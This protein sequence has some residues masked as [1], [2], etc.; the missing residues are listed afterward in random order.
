MI[1]MNHLP[2]R[3]TPGRWAVICFIAVLGAAGYGAL[4]GRTMTVGGASTG[5]QRLLLLSWDEWAV[6][7][8]PMK[9]AHERGEPDPQTIRHVFENI[10]DEHALAE[11]DMF[12]LCIWDRFETTT[13]NG[14]KS[15]NF[16]GSAIQSKQWYEKFPGL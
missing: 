12:A 7:Q 2:R 15:A 10:V 6:W 5:R 13:P 3:W 4:E 9:Q 14:F 11:V 1:N 8:W 16:E